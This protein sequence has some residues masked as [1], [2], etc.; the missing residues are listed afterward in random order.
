M[1][2]SDLLALVGVFLMSC[3]GVS[4]AMGPL[5]RQLYLPRINAWEFPIA[6]AGWALASCGPI[7]VAALFW[8]LAGRFSAGWL[9]HVLLLPCFYALLLA[10]NWL[11]LSAVDVPDFDVTM[12]APILPA[13]FCILVITVVYFSALAVKRVSNREPD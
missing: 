13:F 6:I 10:G 7:L 8:R 9:L 5:F 11:M 2:R 4:F 12:G 3:E 1:R